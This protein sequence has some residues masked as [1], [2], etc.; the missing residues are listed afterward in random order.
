M[1]PFSDFDYLK[2]AFT[3]GEM[4]AVDPRRVDV[5]MR[6]KRI[7]PEQAED[8]ARHGA[9]GSHLEIIQRADGFK[10][11]NQQTVSDIIHRTDP[12]QA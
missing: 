2:Q 5:L 11:F 3:R 1:D 10:G 8:F 7:T 4:W 12:R 9:V 6:L